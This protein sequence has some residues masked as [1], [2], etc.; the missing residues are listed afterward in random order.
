MNWGK[1]NKVA[2]VEEFL[3][4]EGT[5]TQIL[6]AEHWDVVPIG[7]Y[8]SVAYREE[9]TRLEGICNINMSGRQVSICS[10]GSTRHNTLTPSVAG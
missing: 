1:E 5:N 7:L 3:L 2:R 9:H 6:C 4:I 8:I 10:E